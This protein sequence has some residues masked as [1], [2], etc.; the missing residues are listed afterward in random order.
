MAALPLPDRWRSR[1][2]GKSTCSEGVEVPPESAARQVGAGKQTTEVVGRNKTSCPGH[3]KG[4]VRAVT[5]ESLLT[6]L[7]SG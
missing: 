2:E 4:A 7:T 6:R 5:S 3:P 1:K